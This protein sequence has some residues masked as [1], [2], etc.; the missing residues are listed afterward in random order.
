MKTGVIPITAGGEPGPAEFE[1][2]LPVVVGVGDPVGVGVG[3]GVGLLDLSR[4]AIRSSLQ[5]ISASRT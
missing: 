5:A 4:W 2:G 3:S 1:A